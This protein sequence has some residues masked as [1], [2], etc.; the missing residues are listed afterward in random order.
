M[1][2][3][4]G[5]DVGSPLIVTAVDLVS[6]SIW[7]AYSSW[8]TYGMTI[9]GYVGAFA[10]FGGDILKNVGVS[11]LPLTAKRLY[12]TVRAPAPMERM[13]FKRKS[14]ARYPARATEAP[15]QGVKLV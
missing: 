11:S 2:I 5:P 4:I 6:E 10:G 9:V 1:A 8:L 3:K 13:A 7:P 12:D 15:F 14:V